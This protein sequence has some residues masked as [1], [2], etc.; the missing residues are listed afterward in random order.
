MTWLGFGGSG[1]GC[2]GWEEPPPEFEFI[3][4]PPSIASY[5]LDVVRLTAQ[6]VARNG[7]QFLTTLMN[8]EQRN[9]QFDF[10]RPQHSLFLYFT[11]LLEQYTKVLIPHKDLLKKLAKEAQC[12]KEVY[13]QV[14]ERVEWARHQAAL[15]KKEEEALEKERLEYTS[16][17]WHDFSVVETIDYQPW[18]VGTFPPPTVPSEV[19]RRV[20]AQDRMDEGLPPEADM[21]LGSDEEDEGDAPNGRGAPGEQDDTQVQDMEEES[22]SSS[23]DSDDEDEDESDSDDEKS[24]VASP[25][26]PP[27][28]DAKAM[29]PPPLPTSQPPQPAPEPPKPSQ[30]IVRDYDPKQ[31]RAKEARAS[32]RFLVSPITGERIAPDKVDQH[33][34][35]NMLDPRWLETKKKQ[36]KESTSQDNVFAAG[37]SVRS[38]LKLLAE[39]RTDIFGAGDEETII[40]RKIVCHTSCSSEY[41]HQ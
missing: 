21:V 17:D 33:L 38:S 11:K 36:E 13:K 34:K 14:Q 39:R 2:G 41:I 3:A 25:P 20:L 40:G 7:R 29:P 16:I 32:D 22:S 1:A 12:S 15:K 4:D 5:D 18:E 19:G 9:P 6:F 24:K 23:D 30:V 37:D 26:P 10:L 28:E 35:I 8:R 31:E 27:S